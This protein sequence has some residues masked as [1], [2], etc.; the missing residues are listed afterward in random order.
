MTETTHTVF[1]TAKQIFEAEKSEDRA[2]N[3]TFDDKA[4]RDGTKRPLS[5]TERRSFYR[6]ARELLGPKREKVDPV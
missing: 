4:T 3:R 6:R 5:E 2:W 1:L